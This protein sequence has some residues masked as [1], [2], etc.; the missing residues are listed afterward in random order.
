MAEIVNLRQ[1]RKKK[2][3]AEKE[4]EAAENRDR[5][6]RT[7]ARW[8]ASGWSSRCPHAAST[9]IAAGAPRMRT[10]ETRIRKRSVNIAGHPTSVSLE[11]AF[12]D[13][14][15]EIAALDQPPHRR[16]RRGADAWRTFVGH[17]APRSGALPAPPV[18][19]RVATDRQAAPAVVSAAAGAPAATDA[20]AD[21]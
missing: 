19:A 8:N 2:A 11:Q 9:P 16:D 17:P 1:A 20:G 7:K 18:I 3:R 5:F 6:G 14:L 15:A 12:W 21:G 13:G 10:E 4:R